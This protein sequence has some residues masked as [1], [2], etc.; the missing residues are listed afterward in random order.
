[1]S[2]QAPNYTAWIRLSTGRLCIDVGDAFPDI[3]H[4]DL[5]SYV[6]DP[7][8]RASG[9]GYCE[10]SLAEKLISRMELDDIHVLLCSSA[11]YESMQATFRVGRVGLGEIWS[12]SNLAQVID[13]PSAHLSLPQLVTLDDVIEQPWW[14]WNNGLRTQCDPRDVMANGWTRWVFP[15]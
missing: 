8:S 14:N 4:L 7:V 11:S 3:K 10:S 9:I 5:K 6:R 12:A 1:M 2:P 15:S 13:S